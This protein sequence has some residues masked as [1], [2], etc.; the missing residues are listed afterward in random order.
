[1]QFRGMQFQLVRLPEVVDL[2]QVMMQKAFKSLA[3]KKRRNRSY[4]SSLAE[5]MQWQALGPVCRKTKEAGHTSGAA[6]QSVSLIG[7]DAWK[8]QPNKGR[9]GLQSLCV[10]FPRTVHS[11]EES[12]FTTL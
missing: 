6:N 12:L 5:V 11:L 9:S 1:M 4:L 10:E 7:L 8:R 2:A 3:P